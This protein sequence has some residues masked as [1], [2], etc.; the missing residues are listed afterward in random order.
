[1]RK[2]PT[3]VNLHS[4]RTIRSYRG[5]DVTSNKS[6]SVVGTERRTSHVTKR[7]K[8]QKL[9]YEQNLLEILSKFSKPIT[10]N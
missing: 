6:N 4:P 9:E 8:N 2:S 1:M 10:V 5:F 3:N 7:E